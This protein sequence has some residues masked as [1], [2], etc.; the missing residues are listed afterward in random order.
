MGIFIF[1]DYRDREK[2]F[3]V[4]YRSPYHDPF[5][6]DSSEVFGFLVSFDLKNS[7]KLIDFAA[8][9]EIKFSPLSFWT[10]MA[11]HFLSS[12]NGVKI[13]DDGDGIKIFFE[14]SN[15][16][17]EKKQI[18]ELIFKIEEMTI[19]LQNKMKSENNIPS[20]A[21]IAFRSSISFGGIKPV[22]K[23]IV[24]VKT[25][26]WE[27]ARRG[28]LFRD[29]VRLLDH[30][31]EKLRTM[32]SRSTVTFEKGNFQELFLFGETIYNGPAQIKDL[33]IR[34]IIILGFDGNA[35]LKNTA[36]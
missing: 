30:D 3:D 23:E 36:A 1:L 35:F 17:E 19:S 33:G 8:K 13:S 34:Q 29:S 6:G 16:L 10:A 2:S 18:L 20:D 15:V 25:P 28:T 32:F 9:T 4:L 21:S 11:A 14:C 24:G 12:K 27:D 7:S 5:G 22:W 31:K 26:E